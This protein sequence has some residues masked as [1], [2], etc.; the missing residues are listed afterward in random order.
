M[1]CIPAWRVNSALSDPA[2][3][4][5]NHCN[6]VELS[7]DFNHRNLSA[8]TIVFRL[9]IRLPWFEGIRT[10]TQESG[11]EWGIGTDFSSN[12]AL[13]MNL[14]FAKNINRQESLERRLARNFRTTPEIHLNWILISVFR[15]LSFFQL[16]YH[17]FCY[18]KYLF[19][20]LIQ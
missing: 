2:F 20:V 5:R 10:A 4:S 19:K 18:C 14:T 11:H 1:I 17:H 16:S 3:T 13:F 15:R 8:L 6:L 9:Q 12:R 7:A